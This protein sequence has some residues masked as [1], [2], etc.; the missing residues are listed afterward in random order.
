MRGSCPDVFVYSLGPGP[1]EAVPFLCSRREGHRGRHL[2][3]I[4]NSPL[5]R[6]CARWA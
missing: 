6:I 1:A 5:G 3:V 4:H 2:A